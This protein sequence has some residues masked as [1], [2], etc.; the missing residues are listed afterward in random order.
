MNSFGASAPADQLYKN[1]GIDKENIINKIKR[2][3]I[4]GIT[5]LQKLQLMDLE[6]L[7]D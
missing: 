1:F 6:E 4:K 3:I 2:E 7:V 5:W